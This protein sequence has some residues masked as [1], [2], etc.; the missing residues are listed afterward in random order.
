MEKSNIL[1]AGMIVEA[2]GNNNRKQYVT[3]CMT[4]TLMIEDQ[5]VLAASG[6]GDSGWTTS[7]KKDGQGIL[8][9]DKNNPYSDGSFGAKGNIGLD[10]D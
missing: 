6:P 7:D 10:W 2:A 1:A 8:D 4:V 5:A 3:P 9:E